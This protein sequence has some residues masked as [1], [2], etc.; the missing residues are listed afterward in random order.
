MSEKEKI[1]PCVVDDESSSEHHM[2]DDAEKLPE[3]GS[4]ERAVLEH[5][6]VRKLDTRLL[7]TIILIYILN[8]IDVCSMNFDGFST[9]IQLLTFRFANSGLVLRLHG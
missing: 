4:Q 2:Q 5:R 7:P 8:H 1:P 3:S 6:L 9:F